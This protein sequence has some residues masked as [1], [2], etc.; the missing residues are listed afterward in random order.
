[1]SS[2]FNPHGNISKTNSV[3]NVLASY[4][5]FHNDSFVKVNF[6]RYGIIDFF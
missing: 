3:R 2:N 5:I 6:Q 4:V 1:M